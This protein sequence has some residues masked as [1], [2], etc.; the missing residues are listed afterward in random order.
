MTGGLRGI[1]ARARQQS[2][3]RRQR[4]TTAHMLLVLYQ[5]D[6]QV[7]EA[8]RSAG[9]DEPQLLTVLKS[10]LEEPSEALEVSIENALKL[11]EKQG[12]PASGLHLLH[13]LTRDQRGAAYRSLNS[14]E[15]A[16]HRLHQTVQSALGIESVLE[17]KPV[18]AGRA[19]ALPSTSNPKRLQNRPRRS[20]SE[21]ENARRP[22][23]P[24]KQKRRLNARSS[25]DHC[26]THRAPSG[27][28]HRAP[29]G[30]APESDGQEQR[31]QGIP[32]SASARDL[33]S[34]RDTT[35]RRL[36]TE[37][38][39]QQRW[40]QLDPKQFPTLTAVGRNLTALAA[41]GDVDP[42]VGR[43]RELD[44]ILDVLARRRS[45]NP[46][47]IGPPGVGKTAL[48]EG[49][50]HRLLPGA[51]DV[52]GLERKVI[53]E[54]SPGG[55]VRGTGV[56]GALAERVQKILEEVRQSQGGIILFVDEIH[57]LISAGDGIDE[58]SNELKAA[59]ARGALPCIGATTEAEYRRYLE[60]D[61]AFTRRFTQIHV[62][63]PSQ[64]VALQ[65]LEGI[66][67]KYEEH[68]QVQFEDHALSDA[69][70]LSVKHL[71]DRHLPDKAIG[72]ID[73][74]AARVGRRGGTVVDHAAIVSV[75][76][77]W[78]HIPAERLMMSDSE[79][80]LSLEKTLAERVIG[81]DSEIQSIAEAL[82]KGLA[83]LHRK[84]PLATFLLLGPTGVGKT[85]TAQAIAEAL[86]PASPLVRLDLSECSEPHTVSRLVGAPPGYIGHHDGGQL[87]E[88]VRKRPYSLV[89]LDEV[90]KAHPDVL[91]T[92]LPLLDEGHLTDG[93][94][95]RVDF[96]NTVIVMTS[97][98]GAQAH[99]GSRVGFSTGGAASTRTDASG[100]GAL[101]H[102]ASQ[103]H[104]S[105]R[106]HW[107]RAARST[108]APELWNRID[109]PLFFAP[110]TKLQ[111]A[112]IAKKMLADLSS[113]TETEY[114]IELRFDEDLASWLVD[115][116]GYDPE[117]G[118]RPI[119]RTIGRL[120]E[121]PLVSLLLRSKIVAA[122][123]VDIR[124]QRS[125]VAFIVGGTEVV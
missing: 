9:V 37:R 46:L 86:F 59:L 84:K 42:V 11:S 115:E 116:G 53:V 83:G 122:D 49:L 100:D 15:V 16:L 79:R 97:N 112:E 47:L 57:A 125:E 113:S 78:T 10:E 94:G 124:V 118:A 38:S 74:A 6:S 25:P 18:Q 32:D 8:L 26:S 119:R 63:E 90:D 55:W 66:A 54:L 24:R 31:S 71:P 58:V 51:S 7:S 123:Q 48:V 35:N 121:A 2:Q 62:A 12:V 108:I 23:L 95:R 110:L 5:E 52:S 64:T 45:N 39:P 22:T 17:R 30:P 33:S 28:T 3:K 14:L 44:Q 13:V 34:A 114:A 21:A 92:L 56:R 72:L 104:A 40:P 61:G 20:T 19:E 107:L 70:D 106:T 1:V 27:S 29:S 89:L 80:L 43:T 65:I 101:Q 98:H 41:R 81:H 120:I 82:R 67:A 76:S 85:E 103:H 91:M 60:R 111:I 50:A 99:R 87:T 75:L 68:H 102:H 69:I 77:E 36:K 109:E 4:T 105:E 117:L 88:A 73:T 93:V 96:R